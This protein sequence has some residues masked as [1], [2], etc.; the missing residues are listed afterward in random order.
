MSQRDDAAG[1]PAKVKVNDRRRFDMDGN[2][3]E[4]SGAAAGPPPGQPEEGTLSTAPPADAAELTRLKAELEVAQKDLEASRRRVD[5]LARAYQ[6]VSQD[7]EEFKARLRRERDGLIDVERGKVAV[8]LV[9]AVDEL[10][11]CLAAGDTSPLA[12]GVRLIRDGLLQ[13]LQAGGVERLSLVGQPY[14]PNVAE[15]ADMEVT[16]NP[17]DDQRVVAE[18]QA[19]Y[20]IK[21]KV[22]RPA[23]VRIARYVAPAQA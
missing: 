9:E 11:R 18:L 16:P 17:E 1:A 10:D 23:R 15:A 4:T 20:R 5:E 19:G 13:K 21:D 12:Q 6:A 14:D 2:V 7:R 22:I 8:A 3:R